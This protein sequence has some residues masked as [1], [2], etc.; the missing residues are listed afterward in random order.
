MGGLRWTVFAV[1][2]IYNLFGTLPFLNAEKLDE[3][4]RPNW[5]C[6]STEVWKTLGQSP[7]YDLE[8]GMKA[9]IDWYIDKGWIQRS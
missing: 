4:S 1:E 2:K 8:R 7:E 6:D 3:I 5:L 9:T